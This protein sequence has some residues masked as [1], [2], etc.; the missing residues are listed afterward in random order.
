MT[1]LMVI[2]GALLMLSLGLYVFLQVL[3]SKK[4]AHQKQRR[5][6][7]YMPVVTEVEDEDERR[8]IPNGV[9]IK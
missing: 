4:R 1:A 6:L 9:N 5:M 3:H 8:F 2:V 7:K